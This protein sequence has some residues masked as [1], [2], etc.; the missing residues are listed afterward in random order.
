M[1]FSKA[2]G[3]KMNTQ[4]LVVFLYTTTEQSK[5]K[6]E[7]NSIYNSI[8]KKNIPRNKFNEGHE[9]PSRVKEPSM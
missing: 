9:S 2:A 1:S 3:Y 6:Q 8:P 4:G 5:R 7:N